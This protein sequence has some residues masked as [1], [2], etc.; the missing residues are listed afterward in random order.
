MKKITALILALLMVFAFTACGK[1]AKNEEPTVDPVEVRFNLDLESTEVQPMSDDRA[2]KDVLG[3]IIDDF[4]GGFTFYL[5]EEYTS[6]TYDDFVEYIGVDATEY[7]YDENSSAQAFAWRAAENENGCFVIW[8]R[9]GELYA[10][11]SSN[12]K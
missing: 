5:D 4:L 12:L 10:S 6:L 9:D 2:S 7:Y 1:E 3:K 8:F 11:G